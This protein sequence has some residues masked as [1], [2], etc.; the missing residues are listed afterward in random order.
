MPGPA[1]LLDLPADR[2]APSL[3]LERLGMLEA[4]LGAAGTTAGRQDGASDPPAA[5][6]PI[7]RADTLH[8]IRTSTRRVRSVLRA[9]RPWLGGRGTRR[10]RRELRRLMAATSPGRDLDVQLD[11]LADRAPDV[12]EPAHAGVA[13]V[14]QRLE[15]RRAKLRDEEDQVLA[16]PPVDFAR[17]RERLGVTDV[18]PIPAPTL[19]RAAAAALRGKADALEDDLAGV[20]SLAD[21]ERAH[22][23]R[24]HAKRLRYVLEPFVE[25]VDGAP[26]LERLTRLQDDLGELRDA[27]VLAEALARALRKAPPDAVDG[28]KWLAERISE[29]E[30]AAWDRLAAEW[31]APGA[32]GVLPGAREVAARLESHGSPAGPPL[33]IERKYLLST[34]PPAAEAA[35]WL[36]IRQGYLPG[37]VIVERLRQVRDQGAER[38][39]RTVKTGRGVAR[40]ELEEEIARELFEALWPLTEGRRLEKRRYLV[41]EG[42]LL[43]LVDAFTDRPLVLAEVELPNEAFEPAIPHWLR[44]FLLRDVTGEVEYLNS[45]LAR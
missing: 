37:R 42:D 11:W 10:L 26:L 38:W 20:L 8:H 1:D 31:L 40:V 5:E 17:A 23:A 18:S 4:A 6:P 7:P 45:S 41:P 27:Q 30:V 36:E 14:T 32:G 15:R 25:A 2:G 35:P 22:R 28:V 9:Y 16:G 39:S 33:E 13:W 34:L 29:R 44:P 24:I 3:A 21:R 43:W 12:P 19:A